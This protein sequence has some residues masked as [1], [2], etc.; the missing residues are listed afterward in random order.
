ME[1]ILPTIGATILD[2]AAAFFGAL[3]PSPPLALI[4]ALALLI[5]ALI[6]DPRW[7]YRLIPHP[8]VLIGK[9]I[10]FLDRRLNR[11]DRGEKDRLARG[12]VTVLLVVGTCTAIGYGLDRLLDSVHWGWMVEALVV[13][14]L[15]A[16]RSLH[17]HVRRVGT[18]LR[19]DG[20]EGGR[21]AIAHIVSRDPKSLDRHGVARSAIESLS[22]N[23]SDGVVAPIFFYLIFGLPGLFAYKAINTLDSMIAY[24]T[25]KYR[26]FGF[27]AAKLDDLANWLP[28][29]ISGALV[30]LA[31]CFT[32]TSYPISAVKTMLRDAKKHKSPNGGWPEG[33]FA[34]ALNIA[35][36]GPRTYPGGEVV[37]VWIGD[38]RARLEPRDI[39]RSRALYI[40]ANL[41][42]WFAI[43][44]GGIIALL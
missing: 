41:L 8:V 37:G 10:A 6:G 16:A 38:G 39:D 40:V 1:T 29:R 12:A 7:L 13:S 17:D 31:A 4:L 28:A 35:L 22:E 14:I 44:C 26:S 25:T 18:G 2:G 3:P 11:Q 33:A 42:L 43:L 36:G 5:D 30:C 32:P 9:P 20:L 27:T 21:R 23:F 15:L 24:K 19:V 34:G